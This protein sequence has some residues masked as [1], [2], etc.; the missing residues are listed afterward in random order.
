MN[1]CLLLFIV[2]CERT[3]N[4]LLSAES[5]IF[6]DRSN[7]M[8]EVFCCK[9]LHCIRKRKPC[10]PPDNVDFRERTLL[11]RVSMNMCLAALSEQHAPFQ[12]FP[13]RHAFATA[14]NATTP[15]EAEYASQVSAIRECLCRKAHEIGCMM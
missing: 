8:Y 3:D 9:I 11:C 12:C 15:N 4:F 2:D 1:F 7:K 14:H 6:A 5:F 10:T 13:K